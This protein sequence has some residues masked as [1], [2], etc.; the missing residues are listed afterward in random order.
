MIAKLFAVRLPHD[1]LY[2][3]NLRR[4]STEADAR[5]GLLTTEK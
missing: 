2:G 1:S 4:R 5:E 3:Y